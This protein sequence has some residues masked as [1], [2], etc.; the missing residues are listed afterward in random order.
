MFGGLD[1]IF[2]IV[3]NVLVYEVGD[4]KGEVLI[5]Y[6]RKLEVFLERYRSSVRVFD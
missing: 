1:V 3:D 2:N 5:D 4:S 6:Y